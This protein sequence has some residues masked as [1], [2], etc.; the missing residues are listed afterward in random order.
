MFEID[1]FFEAIPELLEAFI[2]ITLVVTI[3][4]SVMA[5]VLG[6]VWAI[7]LRQLPSLVA[8]P[9]AFVLD[10]IRLTPLPVHLLLIYYTFNSL[11]GLTVGVLVFGVHYSTYMAESYRAGIESI[12]SGQ[13]EAATALSLPPSR[14]WRAVILP[15]AI[16]NT[17]PS[18]GNWAIAMFKDTPFL[19]FIS[20]VEMVTAARQFGGQ[21]FT[22]TEAFTVA[23]L[24]FLVASYP[25][26]VL[27]RKLEKKLAY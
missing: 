7:L 1:L 23:G 2:K 20:V 14:T 25:T 5:A 9:L 3:L 4:G 8:A 16:R 21:H 12:R 11:S 19:I 10:F 6:L 15:Q 22:Y 13:W 24:L 26:A 27:M 18:L 17:L